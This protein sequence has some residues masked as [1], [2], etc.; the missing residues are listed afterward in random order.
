MEDKFYRAASGATW[1]S[2]QD[3]SDQVIARELA[4]RH[5]QDRPPEVE[6]QPAGRD[7]QRIADDRHPREHQYR[8]APAAHPVEC[9]AARFATR[10]ILRDTLRGVL[11][12]M[13]RNALRDT[14]R[15]QPPQQPGRRSAQCIA[16]GRN[17]QRRP[18][19]GRPGGKHAGE[20]ELG[21]SR[22]ER[23]GEKAAQEQRR[24]AE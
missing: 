2:G 20:H 4:E 13:L 23:R 24:Q 19:T 3:P 5:E 10:D 16:H 21:T 7:T 18:Q 9:A 17:Q 8:R 12:D 15:D 22:Q 1:T 14:I 11:R 6:P